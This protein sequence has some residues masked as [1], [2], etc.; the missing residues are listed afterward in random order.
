[1]HNQR[2][3]P[4]FFVA[5]VALLALFALRAL[6][7]HALGFEEA[8]AQLEQLQALAGSYAAGQENA[9]TADIVLTYTRQPTYNTSLWQMIA[10]NRDPDFDAYVQTNAPELVELP[11]VGTVSLPNG[12]NIDFSHLLASLQLVCK[13]VPVPG[14]WGG[15][16]MQLVQAYEGQATDKDG[17]VALMQGT[18]NAGGESVFGNED[19]RADLDSVILGARLTA[20]ASV[21]GLLR[22]YYTPTLT[23]YDRAYQFTAL[24]FGNINTSNQIAFRQTVYNTLMDDTGMQFLLYLNGMWQ[25]EGWQVDPAYDTALRAAADLFADALAAAVNGEHVSSESDTLMTTAAGQPLADLLTALGDTDAAQSALDA[26]NARGAHNPTAGGV[27]GVLD[28]AAQH[29]RNDFDPTL[30]RIILWVLLG[31]S[32]AGMVAF[33]GLAVRDFIRRG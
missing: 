19:L 3:I 29:M 15:D 25:R 27:D 6:P 21:A 30:F 2:T 23:D 7:A 5:F 33:V 1:M 18:F 9:D 20:G 8:L 32:L 14:S 10:G 11:Y 26:F 24:T 17:Y 16:C 4:R 12:Q 22:E 28:N 31:A 13:G